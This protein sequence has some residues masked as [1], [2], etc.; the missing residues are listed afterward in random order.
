MSRSERLE[1][2]AD[3]QRDN[4]VK[5]V[6]MLGE[7]RR[8][9]QAQERRLAD[10]ERF[11]HEY[12]QRFQALGSAG[13]TI[14]RIREYRQFNEKLT[15]AIRQQRGLL[16]E[17]GRELEAQ[18]RCWSEISARRRTLEKVID[19]FRLEELARS[20]RREQRESDDGVQRMR[21]LTEGE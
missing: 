16:E 14:G 6:R 10:L 4:E 11:Q 12:Q 5:A 2:I 3:L 8:R 18:N 1:P 15:N 9:Y 17:C 21:L 7:S 19:R 13:A 20:Q